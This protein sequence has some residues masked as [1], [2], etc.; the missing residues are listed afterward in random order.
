MSIRSQVNIT[1]SACGL[2]KLSTYYT[3]YTTK[4]KLIQHRLTSKPTRSDTR[5]L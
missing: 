4:S 3:V 2:G 1:F 5:S